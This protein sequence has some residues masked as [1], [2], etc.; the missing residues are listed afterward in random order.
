MVPQPAPSLS[1]ADRARL[2]ARH[3]ADQRAAARL[4]RHGAVPP[5]VVLAARLLLVAFVLAGLYSVAAASGLLPAAPW[6]ALGATP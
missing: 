1:A 2:R 3:R 5:A 6:S 4:A